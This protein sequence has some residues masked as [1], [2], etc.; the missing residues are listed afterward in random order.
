VVRVCSYLLRLVDHAEFLGLYALDR[1]AGVPLGPLRLGALL[2]GRA[3]RFAKQAPRAVL[4]LRKL[5]NAVPCVVAGCTSRAIAEHGW[6]AYATLELA[7]AAA[8]THPRAGNRRGNHHHHHHHHTPHDGKATLVGE[9]YL[10]V[11]L[12]VGHGYSML[13]DFAVVDCLVLLFVGGLL[14]PFIAPNSGHSKPTLL[15]FGPLAL[16]VDSA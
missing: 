13:S 14:F 5:A 1:L 9:C 4:L 12:L 11:P 10:L 2:A 3:A 15:S 8:A 7:A 16:R 6:L